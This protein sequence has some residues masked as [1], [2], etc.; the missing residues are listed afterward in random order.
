MGQCSCITPISSAFAKN[1]VVDNDLNH[2]HINNGEEGKHKNQDGPTHNNYSKTTFNKVNN[3]NSE[4][5]SK[6]VPLGLCKVKEMEKQGGKTTNKDSQETSKIEK[7]PE[8]PT[9]TK[10]TNNEAQ[11][12]KDSNNSKANTNNL[13]AN[14]NNDNAA[15]NS[16]KPGDKSDNTK[17]QNFIN[18]VLVGEQMVGKSAFVIKYIKNN[19]EKHYIPSISKEISCQLYS[20]NTHRYKIQFIVIPGNE[21][22]ENNYTYLYQ[23]SDFFLIFFD[24]QNQKSYE[25]AKKLYFSELKK[26]FTM[27]GE[28]SNMFLVGNKIDLNKRDI[29]IEE[30]QDFSKTENLNFYEISVKNSKNIPNMMQFLFGL[31]DAFAYPTS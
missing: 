14:D 6:D 16:N 12:N 23:M 29:P 21:Y 28:K 31:H 7:N 20:F 24:Y 26:F 17:K 13:V 4:K 18:I 3:E 10:K 15:A 9:T 19:F 1:E 5:V 8:E 22:K 2:N 11:E 25:Y 27:Y 30:I